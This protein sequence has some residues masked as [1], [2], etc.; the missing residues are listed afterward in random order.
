M[1]TAD[2]A[3]P[4]RSRLQIWI[5]VGV[6]FA[7]LAIAFA[8]YYGLDGWRPPGSTN[9]GTLVTPA[10]PLPSVRLTAADGSEVA[11]RWWQEKW[12][13]V[14]VGSGECDTRCREALTLSRQ[15]RL[16][17]NDDMTR[18]RRVFLATANCCDLAYLQGEHPD[19]LVARADGAEARALLEVFAK[20]AA[21]AAGHIYVVDP[22]GNLMMHYAP[23]APPRGL[24]DDLK[25]LLK[26]SHIG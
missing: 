23:D 25:K 17:L 14:Y 10:Q 7:P 21:G 11:E 20:P 2:Q 16:A 22:L 12:N 1:T 26:L 19:L 24:L 8:L 15:T 13:V 18:V 5:L 3:A 4:R 6:F 9:H